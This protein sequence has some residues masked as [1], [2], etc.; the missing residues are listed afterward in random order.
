VWS[1]ATP[2]PGI[3]QEKEA[4][5]ERFYV[6]VDLH[7]DVIQV[8]TR[9]GSGEVVE[10]QRFRGKERKRCLEAIA[11]RGAGVRVAVEAV[12]LNRWFVNA[13]RE[14]GVDVV[15]VDPT[16][17]G[18]RQ[19]GRK[20]D[21][22]DAREISRRLWLGDIDRNA[23]T[24]YPSEREYATRKL[25]RTRHRLTEQ[26]QRTA[27]SIRAMLNA[28][29]IEGTPPSLW[30]PGGLAWLDRFAFAEPR[31]TACLRAQTAL[32]RAFNE[33]ITLLRSEIEAV[34]QEPRVATAM[35]VLPQVAAITAT[36]LLY[37]LGDVARF[38]GPRAVAAYGG[39]V[40]RVANS[41]DTSHHGA[42]TKHG[43]SELRWVL[44]QWAVRLL[45]RNA[46]VQQWAAPML[47]RMHRNKVRTAL[48]RRLLVGVYVMLCRGEV[49]SLE[50]CLSRPAA[51]A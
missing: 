10:E 43:S 47:R 1:C 3:A 44:S 45:A 13:L 7:R 27:N 34:A 14:R 36:T 22:R 9:D 23:A 18:L 32:L 17:L 33:Q 11:G 31:L 5:V 2:K 20:T 49:F 19:L 37:E 8:C 28:Y 51:A 42:V 26:R 46:Q 35:S 6:G 30:R 12:G 15:V 24:Y 29:A 38:R 48:A 25:V 4:A 21:R 40:P 50:R 16:K 39:L 41:A